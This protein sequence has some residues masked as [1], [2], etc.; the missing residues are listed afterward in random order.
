MRRLRPEVVT[1]EGRTLLNAA[2]VA[3]PAPAL[4]GAVNPSAHRAAD[5]ALRSLLEQARAEAGVPALAGGVVVDG[6]LVAVAATGVRIR[7][8]SVP[9]TSTDRFSL[10]SV[11]KSMTATLAA[12]LVDRHRLR[13]DTT[14]GQAFPELRGRINSAYEGVTLRQ[15]LDHRS[16]LPDD[17]SLDPA[18]LEKALSFRGPGPVARRVFLGTL[19]NTTP[20]NP[21]GGMTYSNA[22]YVV[23][24]AMMERA[25][26]LGYEGLMRRFVFGPLG[27]K[28]AGFGTPGRGH[29]RPVQPS[30]HD[31]SGAPAGYGPLLVASPLADPAGGI[32]MNMEDWSKFLRMQTGE[33]VNGVKLLSDASL[34][35]LHT[36]DPRPIPDEGDSLYGAGWVTVQTKLG[37]ALWHNGSNSLWYAEQILFPSKHAAVFV[38]TNQ[39]GPAGEA[40]VSKAF[41][42]ALTRF[43]A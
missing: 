7:G 6:K 36:P 27:M 34:N 29:A 37:P 35:A 41:E 21:V 31:E 2:P 26:G 24:A 28:S 22:G 1:L 11:S 43:V 17:D 33:R 18:L 15:L 8:N 20:V 23:A 5:Q 10:G 40:A 3:A 25:T 16:G 38:V 32:Y 19:L 39:G 13:W 30:G 12:V 9:V 42:A 4:V 14:V